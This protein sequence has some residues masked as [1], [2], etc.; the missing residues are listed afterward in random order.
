MLDQSRVTSGYDVEIL[1]G[2]RHLSYI[3]LTLVDAGTI[4]VAVQTADGALPIFGPVVDRTYTLDPDVPGLDDAVADHLPFDV[5]I[6]FDRPDGADVRVHF[7]V[8]FVEGD[9]FVRLTPTVTHDADGFLDGASLQI[10]VIDVTGEKLTDTDPDSQ[11][12]RPEVLTKLKD[13]I[14]R[15]VDLGGASAF[16]RVHDLQVRKL[17]TDGEHAAAYALYVNLRLRNGPE[18]DAF[19]AARG[20]VADGLNFL[21]AGSD[22]AMATRGDLFGHL[23]S[24]AWHRFAEI[25]DD[26]D[27]SH[28][29][30]KSPY[31]KKSKK[32]GSIVDVSVGP[33]FT[34]D[35]LRVDVEV[36]YTINNFPDPSGNLV[37]TLTPGVGPHGA[38]RWDIDAD[39][40]A[41]LAWELIGLVALM[42][43]FA[44]G[45]G[46]A[47]LGLG[48]AITTGVIGGMLGD[49]IAHGVLD[50][51]YSDRVEDKVDAGLPDVV[52]GRVAVQR[53]RWDPFY[54]TFH[55]VGMRPD[56][57]LINFN[58]LALWGRAVVDREIELV[59]SVV[60][61][62]KV[63]LNPSPPTAL[64]YRV[65]DAPAHAEELVQV[66][67]GTDRRDFTW[68]VDQPEPGL[69]DLTIPQVLARFEERRLSKERAYFA[70]RVD[71]QQGQVH[72]ILAISDR[73]V[74]E[75]T[76]RAV[77]AFEEAKR[78]EIDASDGAQIRADVTAE[79]AAAGVTPTTEEFEARVAEVIAELV[80]PLVDDYR[81]DSSRLDN[82]V[83]AALE[84]Q[85][86]L[87]MAPE[88]YGALQKQG[89][90][91]LEE[92]EL[93][94][95]RAPG[96]DGFMYYRDHPDGGERDNLLSRPR[97]RET[98]DGI[99][100]L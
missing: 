75:T 20:D 70:K 71:V 63:A 92:L 45:G 31:N 15:T 11:L 51:I 9:L 79:F 53:K 38:F 30:H 96:H 26:G 16:K 56:G 22:V 100:L 12:Y 94:T 97:Y 85:L 84:P 41:S 13:A 72:G 35:S 88:Y 73:E 59:P 87:R 42:G 57:A 1:V 61:R 91:H 86:R 77:A 80:A 28:P 46:I 4:P 74:R 14:D 43:L 2:A 90:L 78:A 33:G 6:L 95:M 37:L 10:E 19:L 34:Q 32:I 27:V 99:E 21:P 58:G 18:E 48:A 62:D 39:F 40:H 98:Q 47:G 29:W 55:Q 76:N 65:W 8:S 67:P 83:E 64:R 69:V 54:T 68:D 50:L 81:D 44:L 25:D 93:I 36:E 24:D 60:I 17:P 49:G 82:D 52:S 89:I 7:F 5:E 66:A 23:A 3:L